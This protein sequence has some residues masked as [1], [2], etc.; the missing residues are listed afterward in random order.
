[1]SRPRTRSVAAA[2][3]GEAITRAVLIAFAGGV[4][5]CAI[6]LALFAV[7]LANTPLP[8]TLVRPL[9]CTAASAGAAFSGFLLAQKMGRQMLLCGLGC[10]AFWAICQAIAA[11]ALN[12]QNLLQGG[13]LM[14]PVALFLGGVLGGALA[15]VRAVR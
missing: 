8:L 15:A 7:L 6:L 13:N 12:R 3:P 14:L 11:V 4:I 5:L 1:M 10:G 2:G 9:A